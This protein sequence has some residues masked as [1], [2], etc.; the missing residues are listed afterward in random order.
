[1]IRVISYKKNVLPRYNKYFKRC[2]H[3]EAHCYSRVVIGKIH[4]FYNKNLNTCHIIQVTKT[5][6]SE[7]EA[8]PNSIS[9]DVMEYI[10]LAREYQMPTSYTCGCNTGCMKKCF[11]GGGVRFIANS[12]VCR[13][14]KK[15]YEKYDV[16]MFTSG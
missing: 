8:K 16:N 5:I 7:Y 2:Q 15:L 10:W 4:N 3:K 11:E 14:E 6:I 1:M 9:V 13:A 12:E